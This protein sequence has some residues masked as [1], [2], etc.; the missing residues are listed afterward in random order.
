VPALI[1]NQDARRFFLHLQGLSHA[2]D[3]AIDANGIYDLI[4]QI[5][6]VQI[7][8]LN[9]VERAHHQ[10]LFSRNQT[11]KHG[12]LRQLHENTGVLFENWTHDASIIPSAYYPYWRHRFERSREQLRQRWRKKRRDGFGEL[13]EDV[14][15]HIE[16]TGP[17]LS[18]DLT[19]DKSRSGKGGE[20]W[21]WHPAK[22]ALEYLWRTGEIAV[23][24]R[25]GF[26]KV[27]DLSARVIPEPHFANEISADAFID[28]SCSSALDRLGFA[29]A[30]EIADFWDGIT[31]DEVKGWIARQSDRLVPV[32][33]ETCN[34]EEPRACLA[35]HDYKDRMSEARVAPSRL[36]VLSPFD[37][38]LRN[39]ARAERLFGFRYRI[40]VYVPAAKRQYGY[41]V[42]PLLEGN[43][44]VGRMDMKAN[45]KTGVLN[46][47]ALWLESGIRASAGRKSRIEAEVE[48]MRK[49]ADMDTVSYQPGWLQS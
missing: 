6:F 36:R 9:T 17:T 28:W 4:E 32:A 18:R 3:R 23:V 46:V 41:Y 12:H 26:Q 20:W 15:N 47:I 7:D 44:I 43:A 21:E 30:R 42:F 25:Q 11:Y 40:E 1:R 39:R 37:P 38:L 19:I 14:R 35:W 49:F 2:P 8:S 45:R 31:L 16:R 24:R 27:Y 33:V 29:T 10:I 5:G 48:R 22:I 13:F 34:T